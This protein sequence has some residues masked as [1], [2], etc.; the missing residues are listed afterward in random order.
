MK[1]I[2]FLFLVCCLV[3]CGCDETFMGDTGDFLFDFGAPPYHWEID[4]SYY[5]TILRQS[6]A[7]DVLDMIHVPKYE[8][9]SQSKSVLASIGHRKKRG[10]KTW[11][12]MVAFDQTCLTA[13]RKYFYIVDERPKYIFN[14]RWEGVCFDCQMVIDCELLNKPYADENA[15]RIA[16][17]QQVLE[18][19]RADIA[20]VAPDNKM[21]GISGMVITHTMEAALLHLQESPAAARYLDECKGFEFHHMNLNKGRI[22]LVIEGDIATVRIRLGS[23][24]RHFNEEY[25]VP[26]EEEQQQENQQM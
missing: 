11:F 1:N 22:G 26:E 10:F 21:L 25:E 3:F 7:A 9:L 24:R 23:L 13:I 17:L 18:Y 5:N 12:N 19:T 6:D 16:V 2:K 4:D 14:D 15:R 8:L 20:E